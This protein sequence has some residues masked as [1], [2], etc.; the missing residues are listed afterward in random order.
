MPPDD[1]RAFFDPIRDAP[2]D[3]APRLIFADWLDEHGQPDRAEFIRVQCAM[4]RLPAETGRWKDLFDR[5]LRL[6]RE[7]RATWTAWAQER[8]LEPRLR[9]GFVDSVRLT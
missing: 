4:D 2:A 1:E 9:R 6:E 5:S 7:G 3:D 8:V